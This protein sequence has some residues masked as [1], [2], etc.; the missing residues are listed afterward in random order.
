MREGLHQDDVPDLSAVDPFLCGQEAVVVAA[1]E[2]DLELHPGRAA[3]GNHL[4]AF[5]HVHGH[6]L[7]AQHVLAGP[8]R[9]QDDCLVKGCRSDDDNRVDPR[10]G[11]GIGVVRVPRLDFELALRFLER[12]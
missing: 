5:P 7:F 6:R 4:V 9:L 2:A 11:Q 8:R 12:R 3:R 10:V 1:H